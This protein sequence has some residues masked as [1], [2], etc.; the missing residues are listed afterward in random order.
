MRKLGVPGAA[1]A[2]CGITLS[3]SGSAFALSSSEAQGRATLAVQ[4]VES[5]M[6]S[7]PPDSKLN[8]KP[9]TPAERIAAGDMLL[10]NKDYDRAIEALS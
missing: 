8:T 9:P 6:T 10:R 4:G 7:A 3:L 2:A 1:F 5:A